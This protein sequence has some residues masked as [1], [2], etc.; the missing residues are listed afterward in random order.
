MCW[1]SAGSRAATAGAATRNAAE[2][3]RGTVTT[4][5]RGPRAA[6]RVDAV[7]ATH[8]VNRSSAMPMRA[9]R[10]S[11][12]SSS[13]SRSPNDVP[14][15]FAGT[16]AYIARCAPPAPTRPPISTVGATREQRIGD[17]AHGLA[18]DRRIGRDDRE[19]GRQRA[20]RGRRHA[21]ADAERPR[22]ARARQ[23]DRRVQ[24]TRPLAARA[25]TPRRPRPARR[26]ATDRA[27][28]RTGAR[29]GERGCRR[30][31]CF[32]STVLV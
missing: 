20:R 7:A 32:R 14:R 6:A 12:S 1:T 2:P 19:L 10:P 23:H 9:A 22:G 15:V 26:A 17:R 4:H 5:T 30:C 8:A 3:P 11:S 24:D 21:E 25:P 28:S 29:T 13:T 27:A 31:A 16:S 18:L